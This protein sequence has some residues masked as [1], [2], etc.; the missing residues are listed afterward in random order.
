M[1][2]RDLCVS[3]TCIT[4]MIR[5]MYNIVGMYG[6]MPEEYVKSLSEPTVKALGLCALR[7]IE[8]IEDICERNARETFMLYTGDSWRDGV[9]GTHKPVRSELGPSSA[10]GA[11]HAAL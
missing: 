2:T 4:G 8:F 10:A 7:A 3:S 9:R 1:V 6:H 11:D 5:L